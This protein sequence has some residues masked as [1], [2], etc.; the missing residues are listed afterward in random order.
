MMKFSD[1]NVNNKLVDEYIKE[2]QAKLPNYEV[3]INN[4]NDFNTLLEE[5]NNCSL[6]KNINECKNIQ[7]GYYTDYKNGSFCFSKC[8]YLKKDKNNF[9]TNYYLPDKLLNATIDKFEANSESRI[10][11]MKYINSFIYNMKNDDE[12][13]GLY[14]HGD[15]SKG[16]TYTLAMIAN[17]LNENRIPSIIAY[18]PVLVS[19]LRNDYYS[20]KDNYEDLVE[21]LKNIDVLLIDDFG[22]EN[23][24]EWLRDEVLGPVINYRMS[25]QLPMFIT[26]NVDPKS[27]KEH[28]AIDKNPDNKMKADRIINRLNSMMPTIDMTDSKKYT[29]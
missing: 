10:K 18:F 27:L 7:K 19:K 2:I 16:K 28:I 22:S 15:F 17:L 29:R 21:S 12:A 11:I 13:I 24:S 4:V 14:I 6:C 26:S 25:M 8:K 23:M 9:I 5:G 3:N 1:N 20:D